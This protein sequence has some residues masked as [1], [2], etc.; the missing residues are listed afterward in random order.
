MN[1]SDE[2]SP[3]AGQSEFEAG[4]TDRA[5]PLLLPLALSGHAEAQCMVANIYHLGLGSVA[6]DIDRAIDW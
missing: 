3:F 6:P 4:E 1:A 5:L 2:N